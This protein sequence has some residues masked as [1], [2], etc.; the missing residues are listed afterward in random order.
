MSSNKRVLRRG[1]G[2]INTVQQGREIRLDYQ[3]ISAKY[4]DMQEGN[5]RLQKLIG[6]FTT[7]P[8]RKLRSVFESVQHQN[9][10]AR[11][12][13]KT[14]ANVKP[15]TRADRIH[16]SYILPKSNA[17]RN[18][19]LHDNKFTVTTR[20]Q[21]EAEIQNETKPRPTPVFPTEYPSSFDY[22]S[23]KQNSNQYQNEDDN[24]DEHFVQRPLNSTPTWQNPGVS[25]N[26]HQSVGFRFQE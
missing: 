11:D 4:L 9:S 5:D 22:P 17:R 10:V 6:K 12:F 15:K 23:L 16:G 19:G 2:S 26:L 8:D 21:K 20:I 7:D 1:L 14:S 24:R 18:E 25:R 3:S 13:R